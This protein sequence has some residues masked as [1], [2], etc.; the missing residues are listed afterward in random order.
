MSTTS[1]TVRDFVDVVAAEMAS[2]VDSAVEYW[3]A[4]VEAALTDPGLTTLGRMNAVKDVLEKYKC[5]TGKIWL[6]RPQNLP[7][8]PGVM[9]RLEAGMDSA[10]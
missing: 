2:G 5:L 1:N 10:A 8:K 3:M 6:Q 9:Q 7:K 4:E